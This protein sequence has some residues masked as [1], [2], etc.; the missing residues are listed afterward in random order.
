MIIATVTAILIL[1]GG[2]AD[3]TGLALKQLSKSV[4]DSDRKKEAKAILKQM[5]G[6]M[7]AHAER[8]LEIRKELFAVELNYESTEA[9]FRAVFR[10][11]DR[12]W[13][14]SETRFR[15][16]RFELLKHITSAEW[17][18]LNARVQAEIDKAKA[19]AEKKAAKKKKK[20]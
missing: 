9:D 5:Q 6:E 1:M 8:V 3:W 13:A 16:L 11:I 20:A 18:D 10:K 15:A 19:K 4:K 7:K 2:G 12:V 17:S 14:E